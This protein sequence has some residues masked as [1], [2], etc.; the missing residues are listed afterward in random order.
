MVQKQFSLIAL[1]KDASKELRIFAIQVHIKVWFSAS[2]AIEASHRYLAFKS[3]LQLS[4]KAFPIPNLKRF[5]N[6][7]GI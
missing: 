3:I 6:I 5:Q 1:A 2:K 7:Y 4:Y